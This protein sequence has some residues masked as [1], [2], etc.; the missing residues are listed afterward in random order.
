MGK[1]VRGEQH[2]LRET[3]ISRIAGVSFQSISLVRL[4]KKEVSFL[5]KE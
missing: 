5:G 4:F 2:A 1:K 3:A